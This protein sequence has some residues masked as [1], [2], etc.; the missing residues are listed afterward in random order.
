MDA[1]IKGTLHLVVNLAV[2]GT[3]F[4]VIPEDFKPWAILVFNLAQVVLAFLDP[5]YTIQK[6]GMTRRE[7]L[8]KVGRN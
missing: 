4:S 6:L 5:T 7:Y 3:I 1:R 8:G 2:N